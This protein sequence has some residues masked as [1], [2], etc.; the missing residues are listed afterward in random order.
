MRTQGF[1]G[2]KKFEQQQKIQ[3]CQGV[4]LGYLS[5]ERRADVDVRDKTGVVP[6]DEAEITASRGGTDA[7]LH[8]FMRYKEEQEKEEL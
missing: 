1:P 5:S 8:R 7:S 4:C 6:M 3:P 2:I